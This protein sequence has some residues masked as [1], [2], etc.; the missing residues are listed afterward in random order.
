M[1]K[2]EKITPPDHLA[3][4]TGKWWVSVV[5]EWELSAHHKMLLTAAGSSWDQMKVA[6]ESIAKTGL[7]Y[8]DRFDAPHAVPEVQIAKDA[9]ALFVRIVRELNLDNTAPDESR[10]PRIGGSKW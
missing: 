5:N 4:E 9:K 7:T 2:T 10:P 8:R 3:T 6:E 1:S